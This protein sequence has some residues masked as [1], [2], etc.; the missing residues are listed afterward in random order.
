MK[1]C[2]KTY[3]QGAI[4]QV[5]PLHYTTVLQDIT[6]HAYLANTLLLP[7]SLMQLGCRAALGKTCC[8]SRLADIKSRAKACL[9]K[10][11]SCCT[12]S[13]QCRLVKKQRCVSADKKVA[14]V[15][16]SG[17]VQHNNTHL[18]CSV[19]AP[20]ASFVRLIWLTTMRTHRSLC[21][22]TGA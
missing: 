8:K 20:A 7:N 10:Q 2:G 6:V 18:T 5:V 4:S 21:C 19:Q 22:I 1:L 17:E 16:S 9:S 13:N 15:H 11:V 3:R 14:Q 12:P